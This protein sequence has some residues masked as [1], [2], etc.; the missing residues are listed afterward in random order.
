MKQLGTIALRA[1]VVF[2]G[3]SRGS[4][5]MAVGFAFVRSEESRI[6]SVSSVQI[7]SRWNMFR[8]IYI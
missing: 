8:A 1:M 4:V 7:D 3:G 5:V 2:S 6:G